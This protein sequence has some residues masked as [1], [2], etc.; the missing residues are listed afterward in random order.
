MGMGEGHFERVQG[1]IDVASV[2]VAARRRQTLHHLYRVF[3]HGAGGAFLAAPVGISELGDQVA[4]LLER[5]QWERYIE[6]PPERGFYADLDIVVI[7]EYGDVKFFLH[8]FFLF[9]LPY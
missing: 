9:T 6:F 2:F 7:D 3:G 1:E 8:W 5:I 4:A